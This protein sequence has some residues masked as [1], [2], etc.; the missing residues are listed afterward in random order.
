[1][2]RNG[3]LLVAALGLATT[4]YL[5][6]YVGFGAVFGA[7]SSLGWG[8]FALLCL[9]YL[10]MFALLSV[11]WFVL[12]P[13]TAPWPV[14]F[15]ARTVRDSAAEVLPLSQFGG[16]VIGARA[17]ALRGIPATLSYASTVVDVTTEMIAQ[18][19]FVVLGAVIFIAQFGLHGAHRSLYLALLIGPVI[20]VLG[21]AGF[22]YVQHHGAE[23][24]V[25]LAR[26]FVPSA[27]LHAGAFVKGLREMYAARLGVVAS[28]AIHFLGWLFS[29]AIALV[30]VRMLGG[31]TTYLQMVAIESAL[32]AIRSAAVFVPSAMGVQ[33]ASYAMLMPMFGMGAGIGVALSLVKRACNITIGIP[34]LLSWQ[35]VEG[36]HAIRFQAP[37]EHLTE[38]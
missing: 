14:F 26:R 10:G 15:W 6:F 12:V 16:F 36:R 17:A 11:G 1:M 2:K 5:V 30:G 20:G 33:E 35:G 29:V 21:A 24:A 38:S 25:R 13:R 19:M 32:C 9:L 3:L 4:F 31:H 22:I 27:A 34:I 37:D 23:V 28:I 18:I 7:I 8:G